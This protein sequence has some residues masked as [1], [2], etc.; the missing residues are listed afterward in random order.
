M[1]YI[2]RNGKQFGPYT[3]QTVYRFVSD[4]QALLSDTVYIIDN[5]RTVTV[6]E[7]MRMWG[8]NPVIGHAGGLFKQLGQIGPELIIPTKAIAGHNWLSDKRLL[9]LAVVGL[10]PTLLMTLP[11]GGFVLFYLVALYFSVIWAIFFYYFFKTGQV[12]MSTTLVVFFA[13]QIFVFLVWDLL[14]LVSLNPFY[15]IL[16]K[17]N[18]LLDFLG[19]TF[20]VGLSEEFVKALP[21]LIIAARARQP[22]IPQTLVYYGLMS[23]IGFGVFEGVQYQMTVN[24]ELD[25]DAAFFMNIARLT[26]LPFLH[27][28]WCGIA[29][30]FISFAKLYPRY[31]LSLYTLAIAVPAVLHGL[32]DTF[33]GMPFGMFI[34]VP[35]TFLAVILLI[36]Y[37]RQGA[38]YQSR[39]K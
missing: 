12:K 19:F 20:G 24:V 5:G 22:L 39:L 16:D 8:W 25:Y 13:T 4:G 10:T 37:L 26:S 17:G 11:L 21:L 30:Y 36:T 34:I 29:G 28:V 18:L 33:C 9:M 27:A 35:I 2:I 3:E 38:V 1:V 23:G 7:L 14:G 15:W 31:R 32:Y 6:R